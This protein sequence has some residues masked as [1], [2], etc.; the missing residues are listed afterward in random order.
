MPV[1]LYTGKYKPFN[2]SNNNPTYVHIKSNH[3]PSILH[4]IPDSINRRL[5]SISSDTTSFTECTPLYQEALKKSRYSH[6]LKFHQ[7]TREN[8]HNKTNRRKPITW[9]NPPYNRNVA[10]NV[11]KEFLRIVREEFPH[12][13]ALSK[14]FNNKTLKVR[15]SCMK[16]VRSVINQHNKKLLQINI[17]NLPSH[18][19]LQQPY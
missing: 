11:G 19:L 14:I 13:H 12:N 3:S 5:S 10:T 15:Y 7:Q 2:K 4:N 18:C 16:N 6:E 1:D 9:F 8:H 17:Y